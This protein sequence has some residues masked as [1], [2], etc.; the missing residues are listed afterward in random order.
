MK[1]AAY[2]FDR[3]IVRAAVNAVRS[4]HKYLFVPRVCIIIIIPVSV[5][6]HTGKIESEKVIKYFEDRLKSRV[7]SIVNHKN[8][9]TGHYFCP[10]S[11]PQYILKTVSIFSVGCSNGETSF[12]ELES[13][14]EKIKTAK[15][16]ETE[17]GGW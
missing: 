3:D 9:C 2:E 17:G 13:P 16:A 14:S 4:L 15:S 7:S 12:E 6:Q 1:K 11:P 8:F 5:A 10:P